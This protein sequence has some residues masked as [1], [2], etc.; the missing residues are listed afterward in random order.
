MATADSH[1]EI[2]ATALFHLSDIYERQV[3]TA[4]KSYEMLTLA[5]DLGDT[6]ALHRLGASY[7]TGIYMGHLVPMDGGRAIFLENMAALA[8]SPEAN[9]A[10]GYRYFYGIGVKQSCEKAQVHYEYAANKA[11]EQIEERRT[12][13][14]VE[15]LHL[16]HVENLNS[17]GR[18]ELD[19]EVTDYYIHLAE[20]GNINAAMTLAN[21]FMSGSR[22]VEQSLSKAA[23]FFTIAA[24]TGHAAASGKLSYLLAL[25]AD[26]GEKVDMDRIL[27]LARFAANKGDPLGLLCIGFLHYRGINVELDFVKAMDYFQKVLNKHP[28][29]GFYMGEILMGKGQKEA[30]GTGKPI[31]PADLAAAAQCY[32][33]SSQ[34]GHPLALHRLSH[35]SAR[36]IGVTVSCQTATTG[37]KNVAEK[38]DWA[39]LATLAH[40]QVESGDA[41]SSILS[42]SRLAVMGIES[43]QFNAAYLLGKLNG[44]LPWINQPKINMSSISRMPFIDQSQNLVDYGNIAVIMSYKE[45]FNGT[46]HLGH[47]Y[48][49][50]SDCEIRALSLHALSAGQSNAEAF[51]IIGDFNYYGQAYLKQNKKEAAAYY[52]LAA[53]LHHPHA[54][55]NLGLMYETGDG[56]AQDFHLAKRFY[57]QAAELDVDARL[58]GKIALYILQNHQSI[59]SSL[60]PI[61]EK[62]FI[63]ALSYCYSLYMKILEI[64]S[65]HN[66]M[67]EQDHNKSMVSVIASTF[68]I[69]F[70]T[71]KSIFTPPPPSSSS[72]SSI[73]SSSWLSSSS[74]PSLLVSKY[75]KIKI[76][77]AID[78]IDIFMIIMLGIAFVSIINIRIARRRR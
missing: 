76:L 65:E 2:L 45:W 19:G 11:A 47:P 51:R 42:F 50:K 63:S 1:R 9:M 13:L 69:I 12:A 38:G 32:A 17:K 28:D 70:F 59:R 53:D 57:D 29:A 39:Y 78:G 37:F 4:S 43:A 21:M 23:H 54:I 66:G 26:K 75:V 25:Q 27:N 72:S 31:I 3:S 48:T 20:E 40:R 67:K 34:Q 16:S 15:K 60:G 44:C 18:R 36:G 33:V 56:V 55:F 6:N 8:G 24:D 58:P 52:M 14:H 7:A 41:T 30:L 49:R 74:A 68:N 64:F 77:N 35:M 46:N 22:F 5:A 71:V 73:P 61:G 10:M 62:W